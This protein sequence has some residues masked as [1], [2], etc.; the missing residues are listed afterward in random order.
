[1]GASLGRTLEAWTF[2]LRG[3]LSQSAQEKASAYEQGI[4]VPASA[5]P[6]LTTPLARD[7]KHTPLFCFPWA[8]STRESLLV[9]GLLPWVR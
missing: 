7:N 3:R 5:L 4:L 8:H 6:G 9:L 2:G 1:M